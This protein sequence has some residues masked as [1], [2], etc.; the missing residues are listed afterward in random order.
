MDKFEKL[1]PL[2][3][4]YVTD[5][6]FNEAKD[7]LQKCPD[8]DIGDFIAWSHFQKGNEYSLKSVVD[9]LVERSDFPGL[10]YIQIRVENSLEIDLPSHIILEFFDKIEPKIPKSPIPAG[11]NNRASALTLTRP[12]IIVKNDAPPTIELD[13]I[14]CFFESLF[15]DMNLIY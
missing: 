11:P 15:N 10:N 2:V 1:L 14:I 7:H 12:I 8:E 4:K 6:K 5:K 13:F 3:D 9:F